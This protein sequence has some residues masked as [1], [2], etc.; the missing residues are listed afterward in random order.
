VKTKV[1]FI[2]AVEGSRDEVKRKLSSLIQQ[3]QI[4]NFIPFKSNVVI[5][6]H[7]GEEG[8]TGFVKPQYV[9]VIVDEV[10]KRESLVLLADT[11]TLYKGRRTNSED[12]IQLAEEHGFTPEIAGAEVFIPDDR[13]EENFKEVV[14]DGKYIKKAKVAKIFI[15][16]DVLISVAHFKGHLMTSFGGALKNIGMG[17]ASRE[18]KLAQH[19][20]VAPFVKIEECIGCGQCKTVCPAGAISIIDNRAYISDEECIGCA[21]CI[22]VCP[23]NAIDVDWESGQDT[24]QEKM[25]EYA[26]AVLKNRKGRIVFFNFLLKIT[27]ECDCLAKDDPRVVPD[28]G[29][30]ASY[31][32]VSIDKASYDLVDETAGYDIFRELHPLRN[33][34]KQL[35][36]ACRIGLG[37]L[38]YELIEIK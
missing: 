22:A 7:F 33:G 3:S 18:G 5:K 36:H 15:D 16:C 2:R 31:D 38:D 30:L 6:M 9:K 17:C 12:H 20:D 1:Y 37:N 14:V 28:I 25:A 34:F 35:R 24:I 4:L 8:N 29:I 21:H 10:K 11:N 13:K 32:P 27:Q 23:Q 19:C 26:L